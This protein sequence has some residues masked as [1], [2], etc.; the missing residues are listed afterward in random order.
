MFP[1]SL[2]SSFLAWL[3]VQTIFLILEGMEKKRKKKTFIHSCSRRS[4]TGS[5][6]LPFDI[7]IENKFGTERDSTGVM[8]LVWHVASPCLSTTR[9]VV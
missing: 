2:A 3:I 7:D 4:Q 8:V 1:S 9:S 6:R 5:G